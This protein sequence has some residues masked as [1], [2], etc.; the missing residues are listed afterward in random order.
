MST[1]LKV[2]NIIK[3]ASQLL[4]ALSAFFAGFTSYRAGIIVDEYGTLLQKYS[5][6]MYSLWGAL[7]VPLVSLVIIHELY[8]K[9]I[10]KQLFSRVPPKV[11]YAVNI[12]C[13]VVIAFSCY[14]SIDANIKLNDT[15]SSRAEPQSL[16]TDSGVLMQISL[17]KLDEIMTTGQTEVVYVTFQGCSAFQSELE[18]LHKDKKI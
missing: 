17:E 8:S 4:L 14:A 15:V 7:L 1:K 11:Y 12:L 9:G 18:S 10:L 2:F 13:L 6:P 16:K 5:W 3:A